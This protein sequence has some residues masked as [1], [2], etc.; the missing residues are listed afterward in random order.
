M[1]RRHLSAFAA[2]AIS[3]LA[4]AQ[5][6]DFCEFWPLAVGNEWDYTSFSDTPLKVVDARRVG[7]LDIWRLH[8]RVTVDGGLGSVGPAIEDWFVAFTGLGV[9]VRNAMEDMQKPMTTADA[10]LPSSFTDG[11]IY[12]YG[13]TTLRTRVKTLAEFAV[14]DGLNVAGSVPDTTTCV[15]MEIN[16]GQSYYLVLIFAQG[17]GPV[18]W[19]YPVSPLLA[20]SETCAQFSPLTTHQADTDHDNALSLSE[21]LRLVQFFN[22]G[23]FDCDRTS[24]DGFRPGQH[25]NFHPCFP[26]DADYN[27]RDWVIS[28]SE[29]LRA[30]QFFNAGGYHPC[31]DAGS[32]DGYCPGAA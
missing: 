14:E 18:Y 6:Y 12:P 30:I 23:E 26:H 4:G 13:Q 11:G 2:A 16:L 3:F 7:D 10:V 29:L 1:S 25:A 17:Y 21:L 31:P 19:F 28:L 15:A 24:E 20:D 9:Y 22:T 8:D 32:E 27:P 5:T